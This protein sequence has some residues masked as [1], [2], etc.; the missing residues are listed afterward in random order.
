M[1]LRLNGLLLCC[2]F[3]VGCNSSLDTDTDQAIALQERSIDLSTNATILA[4]VVSLNNDNASRFIE[5]EN[6]VLSGSMVV[7]ESSSA[8]GGEYITVNVGKESADNSIDFAEFTVWIAKAGDYKIIANALGP[9]GKSNSFFAQIDQGTTYLWGISNNN[10]WVAKPIADRRDGDVI[11]S[12]TVGYHTLRISLRESGSQ[13]DY[14]NFELQD[15][16][17]GDID[18]PAIAIS[19]PTS[20]NE[21][22]GSVATLSGPAIDT[23]DSGF[24]NVSVSLMNAE[25]DYLDFSTGVFKDQYASSKAYLSNTGL[26]ATDWSISTPGLEDGQYTVVAKVVDAAGN[27][28]IPA[29]ST[30]NVNSVSS[31]ALLY[32]QAEDSNLSGAMKIIADTSAIGGSYVAVPED[33]SSADPA[34][35]SMEFS[36]RIDSAGEYKIAARV[37][38]PHGS[39]NSFLAQ[40]NDGNEYIWDI[41][42]NNEWNTEYLSDRGKGDV[43][44]YLDAGS[45]TLRVSL[46]EK[47]AKLDYIE[48]VQQ[49]SGPL[50]YV[51]A[52]KSQLNGAMKVFSDASATQGAYVSL[53]IGDES[54]N[55]QSDYMVF[56]FRTEEA[57]E[58]KVKAR[59]LGPDGSSNSFFAQLNDGARYVW[60]ISKANQWTKEYMSDRGNG[61]VSVYLNAGQQTMRVSARESGSRLDYIELEKKGPGGEVL[62]VEAENSDLNGAMRIAQDTSVSAGNYVSVPVGAESSNPA[63]DYMDFTVNVEKAGEYKIAARV[64][65][66]NGSANSFFAQINSGTRYTWDLPKNNQ[67]S[68]GFVSNRG[69]GEVSV[70]LGAGEHK[71]RVSLRESGAQLDYIE[72]QLQADFENVQIAEQSSI[73]AAKG[74]SSSQISSEATDVATVDHGALASAPDT[75]RES[76][77]AAA[78]PID[79]QAAVNS[80]VEVPKAKTSDV[81]TF[82]AN[83]A[84]NSCDVAE[85]S[86]HWDLDV[87]D[88]KTLTLMHLKNS[89]KT[90]LAEFDIENNETS[91]KVKTD[92]DFA[93]NGEH[94]FAVYASDG[95]NMEHSSD[96]VCVALSEQAQ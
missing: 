5:A 31:G 89:T 43:V 8:S 42:K 54:S 58:Y 57:G 44:T 74:A 52:E 53:P 87:A 41:S 2:A 73:D 24:D 95:S 38:G 84:C 91:T 46:R 92:I 25:G 39:A 36:L 88:Y 13:L 12:L 16:T 61:E 29:N 94:C 49:S 9:D 1:K 81:R 23:G 48:L 59:V 18:A 34:N 63:N 75:T 86:M 67:W 7:A 28:G 70:F 82:N 11:E 33:A 76:T 83:I 50:L 68:T 55:L 10:T 78:L 15:D 69:A 56:T 64:L 96:S 72:F 51:E 17:S 93:A 65:G 71:L 60:D 45:H 80:I 22:L 4:D 6:A 19:S 62:Y 35:D 37:S 47:G 66:P 90:E 26:N 21:V 77:P 40:L 32:V 27:H 79:Q 30:F 14:I 3:L 85:L 20:A